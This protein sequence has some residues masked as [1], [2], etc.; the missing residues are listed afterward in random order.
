MV[1]ARPFR[2]PAEIEP[3]VRHFRKLASSGVV[4]YIDPLYEETLRGLG[5]FEPGGVERAIQAALR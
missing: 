1:K 2:V 5:F 3:R 4:A